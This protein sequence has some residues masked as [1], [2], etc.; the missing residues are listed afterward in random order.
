MAAYWSK[1]RTANKVPVIY[2]LAKHVSRPR[3][4]SPGLAS[5]RREKSLI[6]RPGLLPADE[7]G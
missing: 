1:G 2:T 3:G 4:G 7:G 5:V 6:V